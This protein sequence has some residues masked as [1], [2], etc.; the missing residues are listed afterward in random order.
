MTVRLDFEEH[1]AGDPLL[2][3]HGFPLDRRIWEAV[4]PVLAGRC[5]V[6]VPDLR[7]FGRSA[8]AGEPATGMEDYARDLFELAD[9]LGLDRFAAAGHSMGGYVLLAMHRLAPE[10]LARMAFVTS[11]AGADDDAGKRNREAVALRVEREG[12]AFLAE[13]MAGKVLAPNPREDVLAR[14]K[15]I[16][17]SQPA[18]G[19][20]AASR[21]MAGRPDAR[22]QLGLIQVPSLVLA[23]REDR[24]VPVEEAEAMARAL[25]QGR[26]VVLEGAGHLP[27]LEQPEATARALI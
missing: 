18:D 14:V 6:I 25:S 24:I 13:A 9:R 2:L 19:V 12:P 27:M 16:I 17:C 11:R 4:V 3:I 8:G 23:G 26:L 5:R 21:A 15:E 10:R 22:E 20:A 7:G 1:G